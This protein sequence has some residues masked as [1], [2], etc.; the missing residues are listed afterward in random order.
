MKLGI[1][2]IG[3]LLLSFTVS[4]APKKESIAPDLKLK[5][6]KGKTIK[7]SKLKGEMVLIDFWASWCGPCRK[8]NPNVVEA[9]GKNKKVKF[10]NGNGFEVISISLDRKKEHWI[11]AIKASF[12]FRRPVKRLEFRGW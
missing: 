9:Y 2:F 10:K 6:P 7:L 3:I 11:K 5:S 1:A 4:M 8:E 12:G